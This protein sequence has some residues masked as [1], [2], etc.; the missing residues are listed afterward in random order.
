MNVL[1][2]E[3]GTRHSHDAP[4]WKHPRRRLIHPSAWNRNSANFALPEFSE[5]HIPALC[6]APALCRNSYV[7]NRKFVV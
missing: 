7:E 3:G 2:G 4:H 1:G 5:V 6:V